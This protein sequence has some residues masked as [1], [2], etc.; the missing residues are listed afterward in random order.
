MIGHQGRLLCIIRPFA[1][2]G[3]LKKLQ[4]AVLYISAVLA[5]LQLLWAL[6]FM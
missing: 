1:L 3:D 2:R 4:C 5:A 6:I